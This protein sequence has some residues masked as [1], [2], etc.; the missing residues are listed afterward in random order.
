ME[1]ESRFSRISEGE[2]RQIVYGGSLGI[3]T[4]VGRFGNLI[5]EGK[6]QTDKIKNIQLSP[7]EPMN[8]KR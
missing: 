4:Q 6:Y 5:F 3:G 2:Y 1:S 8:S 7:V